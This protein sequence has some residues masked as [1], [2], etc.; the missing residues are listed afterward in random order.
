MWSSVDWGLVQGR[1]HCGVITCNNFCFCVA[2]L[3]IVELISKPVMRKNNSGT[4]SFPD[5]WLLSYCDAHTLL[6]GNSFVFCF[7]P[8]GCFD[9]LPTG[10]F[11]VTVQCSL[12]NFSHYFSL[13]FHNM[14]YFN[15]LVFPKNEQIQLHP[16][17]I[18]PSGLEEWRYH[19]S[20]LILFFQINVPPKH[21]SSLPVWRTGLRL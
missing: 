1:G 5:S 2:E 8:D 10:L 14:N 15:S 12:R 13:K 4:Y 20:I 18:Q 3:Q 19:S 17:I 6:L 7:P 16:V 21:L 11:L 9:L